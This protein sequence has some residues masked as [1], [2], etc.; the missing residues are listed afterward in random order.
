MDENNTELEKANRQW[1]VVLESL[2]GSLLKQ[3]F[4]LHL[5]GS[6]VTAAN[7]NVWTV[8]VRT[9]QSFQWM[10]RLE[11]T[12]ERL[13]PEGVK[14]IWVVKEETAVKPAPPPLSNLPQIPLPTARGFPDVQSNWTK[15]PDFFFQHV[16]AK[17]RGAAFKVVGA[18]ILNTLCQVDKRGQYREWWENVSYR[19]FKAAAGLAADHSVSVGI[20]EARQS[21]WIKRRASESGNGF[22]YS[23]RWEDEPIDFPDSEKPTN[24]R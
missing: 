8:A 10:G 5:A 1:G 15:C 23:L 17:A 16:M 19:D 4:D 9:I 24:G 22:D 3:V 12:V 13:L 7:G 2:R 21:G 11:Q 6:W 18:V 14:V 20:W